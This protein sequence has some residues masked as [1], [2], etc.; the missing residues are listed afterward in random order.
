[1]YAL[2]LLVFCILLSLRV[3][4]YREREAEVAEL[5]AL[6]CS[7]VAVAPSHSAIYREVRVNE[8]PACVRSIR[9]R[10]ADLE[11]ACLQ[12]VAAW[13]LAHDEACRFVF[14]LECLFVQEARL[15]ACGDKR[16]EYRSVRKWGDEC[17]CDKDR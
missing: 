15:A 5:D 17:R 11:V 9:L 7:P 2:A 6:Y 16:Q 1:M 12:L 8:R 13:V 3:R 10:V 4:V 14:D